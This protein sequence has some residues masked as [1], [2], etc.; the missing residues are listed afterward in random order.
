MVF[1]LLWLLVFVLLW[2]LVS[3][4]SAVWLLVHLRFVVASV[5]DLVRLAFMI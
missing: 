3:F 5:S 2:F 1:V 4:R